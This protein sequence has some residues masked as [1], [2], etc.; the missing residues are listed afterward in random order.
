MGFY[1][2]L[3][4]QSGNTGE[5]WS[6]TVPSLLFKRA[7]CRKSTIS[8][9]VE[10]YWWKNRISKTGESD[11]EQLP[12]KFSER[13]HL[14][15]LWVGC[16]HAPVTYFLYML[17]WFWN[18]CSL[19]RRIWVLCFCH[20]VWNN[21]LVSMLSLHPNVTPLCNINSNCTHSVLIILLW[22]FSINIYFVG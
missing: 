16:T 9:P 5:W 19:K 6:E 22:L 4:E 17:N 14:N 10:D 2:K 15:T 20:P 12:L 7:A 8:N 3:A 11:F 1:D 21:C 18:L 13:W